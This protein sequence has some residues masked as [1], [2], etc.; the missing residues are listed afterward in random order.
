MKLS[1]VGE[2]PYKVAKENKHICF[3]DYK[4]N[5]TQLE[6]YY[7]RLV[8]K[9]LS[10][11]RWKKA[12]GD[13][14]LP[15]QDMTSVIFP[16]FE[17]SIKSKYYQL[18]ICI[19]FTFIFF[20]I[21]FNQAEVVGVF[22]KESA[23]HS[24]G[25]IAVSIGEGHFNYIATCPFIQPKSIKRND[26]IIKENHIKY[27]KICNTFCNN[28]KLFVTVDSVLA[29]TICNHL[30]QYIAF[31]NYLRCIRTIS[32]ELD[33]QHILGCKPLGYVNSAE[34]ED[35]LKERSKALD[36]VLQRL[37]VLHSRL[38]RKDNLLESYD[39]D[40]KVLRETEQ[41]A[42]KKT[43]QVKNLE[44]E[45]SQYKDEIS[46]LQEALKKCRNELDDQTRMNTALR[47]RKMFLMDYKEDTPP[48]QHNCYVDKQ[49]KFK[50]DQ[51][52]KKKDELLKKRKFEIENL[53]HQLWK[54][55]MELSNANYKLQEVSKE[56]NSRY[57][58]DA[59]TTN[60]SITE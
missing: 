54:A 13:P 33:I 56:K 21:L 26:K 44:V 49:K 53:K 37:K 58:D 39:D 14:L 46:Y 5:N 19:F 43:A 24:K 20:P 16:V 3:D 1:N 48:K 31:G 12:R 2:I 38:E 28:A 35:I 29:S 36:I 30:L 55:D 18:K 47:Q 9:P 50:D 23:L 11:K 57:A 42:G 17:S 7:I 10:L 60:D 45:V 41:Y 40:L 32:T 52:S 51:K 4:L 22:F 27:I 34:R 8:E 59:D 15:T 25:Y 6:Y